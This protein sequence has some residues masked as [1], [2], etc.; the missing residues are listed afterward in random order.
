MPKRR[1][2][3]DDLASAVRSAVTTSDVCRALGLVPCGANYETIRRVMQ[4]A[5]ID[6]GHLRR[7]RPPRPRERGWQSTPAQRDRLAEAVAASRSVAEVC[8]RLGVDE[9]SA[10]R[11]VVA[12]IV[13]LELETSHFLGQAWR[14]GRSFAPRVPILAALAAGSVRSTSEIR[15]RLLREGI[16]EHRCEGCGW[17]EWRGRPIPLELDHIDGDRSNN[18][19][20]NL[21][22]LCPN[23]HAQTPTYRGRNIGRRGEIRQPRPT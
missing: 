13:E 2:T 16:R 12:A 11:A 4:Q 20:E 5:G 21:R 8:R 6:D 23:C 18:Q 3:D 17:C 14:R 15:R 22:L 10:R 7:R 1:W 9:V 19:L